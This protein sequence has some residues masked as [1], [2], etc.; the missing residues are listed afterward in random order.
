MVWDDLI[1][2]TTSTKGDP[3]PGGRKAKVHLDFNNKPGYV[4][5][6]SV[7]IDSYHRIETL[8]VDAKTGRIEW[9]KVSYEG[10]MADDH[11]SSSN[12]ATPT[13]VTDGK[14]VYAFFESLGLFAYE[15][16]NG[17]LKWKASVGDVIKAGLGPG[18]SPVL[19]GDLVILQCDQEMG[20]G[21]FIT[22]LDKKTGKEVWRSERSNR[23]SW[24][25]P[26]LLK[27]ADHFELVASGA[28]SVRAYDPETGKELWRANGTESHPIPSPVAGHGLVVLTA[29]SQA[30]RAFAV[31]PGGT[32]DLTNSPSIV[33]R[34]AKGTAY[35]ASP[36]FYGD[37]VYLVSDAGIVTCLKA[38]TGEAVYE[39]G[40]MPVPA[41]IRASL[42][43]FE[44]K[45]LVTSTEGGMFV[46]KAGPTFEVLASN[47]I[48][49]PVWASPALSRGTI[50]V[51]GD[52]HLFAISTTK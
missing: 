52:R 12:Y 42:V 4:H 47:S 45:L 18:T 16:K 15:A 43:A 39:G 51:R 46:V 1:F 36:V 6:D 37:Y 23:R 40:R 26:L 13:V 8:A 25:T 2:L 30:K 34:Y 5:P 24:A 11:H 22:A 3:V 44:G 48:D 32:G 28:E 41:Q 17:N 14:L 49:E 35:V 50:Y 31:R 7:G 9:R 19:F 29:G 38:D 21:S 33:W 27:V 10:L 20:A